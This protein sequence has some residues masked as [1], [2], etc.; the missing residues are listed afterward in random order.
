[1]SLQCDGGYRQMLTQKENKLAQTDKILEGN[2]YGTVTHKEE[3]SELNCRMKDE[4]E[5][6]I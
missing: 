2:V 4:T 6:T 3:S 1:M 5:I